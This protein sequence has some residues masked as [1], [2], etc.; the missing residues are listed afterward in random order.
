MS[1]PTLLT[2]L[3]VVL[4]AACQS[5]EP[6]PPPPPPP[7]VDE[8]QVLAL[9]PP[10]G[11]PA[12]DAIL[13]ERQALAQRV[14]IGADHWVLVG[15][16]WVQKARA[17][18]DSG[19][20]LNAGA[21]ADLAL[22]LAPDD[23][24]A[25]NLRALVLLDGHRFAEARDLAQSILASQPDDPMALATLSD[26]LL[27]LGDLEGARQAAQKRMDR[28]P[29]LPA[30]ARA[31][32]LRWLEGD[33]EAAKVAIR[34]AY[35]AGRGSPDREPTAW[36]LVQAATIFWHEGDYAGA[37]EGLRMAL[38]LLPGYAP[39]LVAQ[40]RVALGLGQPRE[41]V[42]ACEAAL[43]KTPAAETAWLLADAR[44]AAG[45]TAGADAA[46]AQ[47]E[48]LGRQSDKRTLALLL[49]TLGRS[50][51]EAV[52][53]AE[54]ERQRRPGPYTEDA[55]A[56]AV[57]RAGRTAEARPVIDRVVAL[58]MRDARLWYHAGAIHLAA[59]DV[60]SGRAWLEKALALNPAFDATG[61]ADARRLL[62][63]HAK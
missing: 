18:G 37:K 45:D 19:F 62:D 27:E 22:R 41:A 16:A 56:W 36:V 49:A 40:A 10:E 17:S 48:R 35:D 60:A 3:G 59:G 23:R 12:I 52:A 50:P 25:L 57:H 30:Y 44:R 4:L 21:A 11:D 34:S 43:A 24:A 47:A 6:A 55:W 14:G 31:S 9:A 5:P 63:A 58:G 54:A 29:D 33:V 51:D 15:H 38:E 8:A 13:K 61:A 26:A 39:A 1:R 42:T 7:S 28:K 46:L 20:H 2:L 53:F 32:Y